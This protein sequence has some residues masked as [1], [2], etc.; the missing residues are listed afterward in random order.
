MRGVKACLIS[1]VLALKRYKACLFVHI[2][3][4]GDR[5]GGCDTWPCAT[6]IGRRAAGSWSGI[7]GPQIG[8]DLAERDPIL[9]EVAYD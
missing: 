6:D 3:D 5:E 7:G 9:P 2:A 8:P 4:R 1:W